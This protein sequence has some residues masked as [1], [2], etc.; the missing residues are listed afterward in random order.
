MSHRQWILNRFV[1]IFLTIY[2]IFFVGCT[3]LVWQMDDGIYEDY[4]DTINSFLMT[5]D[6][7]KIIFVSSKY[8]YIFNNNDKELIYLLQHRDKISVKFDLKGGDYYVHT[9]VINTIDAHFV[10]SINIRKTEKVFI[11]TIIKDPRCSI[12]EKENNIGVFFTLPGV[13]YLSNPQ[14]NDKLEPLEKP[15]T[16][17]ITQ[18]HKDKSATFHKILAT[19]LLV[20][21]DAVALGAF[22]VSQIYREI[23]K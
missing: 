18:T 1:L 14:I 20:V 4:N 8:H 17:K 5:D 6:S 19:P 16:L 10:A 11:D 3:Q 7:S 21:G 22:G 23:T 2:G 12:H 15:I 13:R 9:D